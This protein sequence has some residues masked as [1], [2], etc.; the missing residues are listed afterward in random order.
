MWRLRPLTFL[1]PSKPLFSPPTPV[2]FTDRASTMLALGSGSRP[3]SRLKR[4]RSAR[5]IVSHV[6]SMLH[7]L[8]QS[9]TV[10]QGGKS[11][12]SSRQGQPLLST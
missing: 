12:G 8:N 2:V 9:Y 7:L 3:R 6:P 10:F 5:F 11:F 4:R 1:P